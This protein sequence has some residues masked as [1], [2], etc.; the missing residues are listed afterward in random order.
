[1]TEKLT[2]ALAAYD[3]ARAQGIPQAVMAAAIVLDRPMAEAFN[4]MLD[5]GRL[6]FE[7]FDRPKARTNRSGL[8]VVR[9]DP[10]PE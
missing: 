9:R 8:R 7:F 1:M 4:L 2:E 10:A 5:S 6:A 3:A